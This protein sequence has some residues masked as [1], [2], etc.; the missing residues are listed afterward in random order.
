MVVP[1]GFHHHHLPD[2]DPD[3]D[4]DPVAPGLILVTTQQLQTPQH[5]HQPPN[6]TTRPAF[7]AL[8]PAPAPG[9]GP[10]P[11]APIPPGTEAEAEA[12]PSPAHQHHLRQCQWNDGIRKKY[13]TKL[14]K[15]FE[16]LQALVV[17]PVLDQDERGLG[18]VDAGG[19]RVDGRSTVRNGMGVNKAKV[20]DLARRRIEGLVREAEEMARERRRLEGLLAGRGVNWVG[21]G[22][23][24]GG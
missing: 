15:Q 2:P 10:T 17:V 22:G 16:R 14:S 4:P 23:R 13:R 1:G 21:E 5:H 24:V 20:L 11:S 8:L 7:P 6:A 12:D 3:P 19:R 18:G 9:P